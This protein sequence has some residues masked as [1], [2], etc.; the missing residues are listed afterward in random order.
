MKICDNCGHLNCNVVMS[1]KNRVC[2]EC[3]K[4]VGDY[5]QCVPE[6]GGHS[7][8]D[9]NGSS[10]GYTIRKKLLHDQEPWE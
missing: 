5:A 6:I 8:R 1:G 10:G 4:K 3:G 7:D 9:E 2:E